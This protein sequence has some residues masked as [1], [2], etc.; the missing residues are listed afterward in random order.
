MKTKENTKK[1]IAVLFILSVTAA[2]ITTTYY[3]LDL[4]LLMHTLILGLVVF[5]GTLS[6]KEKDFSVFLIAISFVPLIRMLSAAVPTIIITQRYWFVAIYVP[7]LVAAFLFIKL[8]SVNKSEI[9]IKSFDKTQLIIAS[10]GFFFGYLEYL[11]LS[12]PAMA[13]LLV[14]NLISLGIIMI[15]CTGFAEELIF[16][17]LIFTKTEKIIGTVNALLYTSLIF[18]VM[19]IPWKSFP[20]LIF[21]FFVGFFYGVV[22]IRTRNLFGITLSHGITN[23]MLFVVMPNI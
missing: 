20:D 21:V 22:F 6:Y 2:E 7:L 16:R 11:I 4:G 15:I 1:I 3:S 9:G 23:I 18:M 14:E 5:Y 13:E 10:T 12:P 17:G 19:H 8:F